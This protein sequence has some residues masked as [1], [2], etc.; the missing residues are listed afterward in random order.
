M[1]GDARNGGSRPVAG[2]VITGLLL[3]VA[4]AAVPLLRQQ[5]DMLTRETASLAAAQAT[6]TQVRDSLQRVGDAVRA[7]LTLEQA[8]ATARAEPKLHLVIAV[9][10]G[11]VA[12][13]RD[14]VTLR[15]MP[16]KFRGTAQARGTQVIARLVEAESAPARATVDSLGNK[17]VLPAVERMVQRVTLGD[18][19]VIEGGDAATA[20]LGGTEAAPG[21]RTIVVSRRDFDAIRPNLVKGMPVVLF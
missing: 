16:A 19:T 6:V 3:V 12:L 21:P 8:R 4:G 17:V 11:T 1:A 18:G 7:A 13:M 10:S 2:F 9:D 5:R 14:G 15:S 20:L